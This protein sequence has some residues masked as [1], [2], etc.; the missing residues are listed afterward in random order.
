MQRAFTGPVTVL[1]NDRQK[2]PERIN[3]ARADSMPPDRLAAG[4]KRGVRA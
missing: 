2:N 3:A 1:S 4:A